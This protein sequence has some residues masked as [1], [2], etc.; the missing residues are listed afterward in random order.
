MAD[1]LN[2]NWT[3][4]ISPQKMDSD[5]SFNKFM[6]TVNLNLDKHMPWKKMS[7]KDFKLEAK[8]WITPGILASIKR[9]DLLLQKYINAPE[10]EN[11]KVFI[12]NTRF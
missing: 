11:K 4:V 1:F 6:E 7:K 9:R 3:E 5:F 8:P 10:G 12:C 2:I